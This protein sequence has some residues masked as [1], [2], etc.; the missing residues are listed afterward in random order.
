MSLNCRYMAATRQLHGSYMAVTWQSHMAV[1]WQLRVCHVITMTWQTT[2]SKSSH[3]PLSRTV[4]RYKIGVRSCDE[5]PDTTC[6]KLGSGGLPCNYCHITA[7]ELPRS[8]IRHGQGPIWRKIEFLTRW[9]RLF[10]AQVK[11][12]MD[13]KPYGDK[14]GENGWF[15]EHK[16]VKYVKYAKFQMCLWKQRVF[17]C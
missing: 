12:Y 7:R 14:T 15:I 16:C 10:D 3:F 1:I 5:M 11:P 17:I 2:F 4:F 6:G 13:Q 8:Q 9:D